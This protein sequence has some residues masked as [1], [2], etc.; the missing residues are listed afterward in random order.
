ML[1]L[2][3]SADFE[4]FTC[5]RLQILCLI[6][7]ENLEGENILLLSFLTQGLTNRI[8]LESMKVLGGKIV[9]FIRVRLAGQEIEH[10]GFAPHEL[11]RSKNVGYP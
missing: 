6:R 9:R 1:D 4:L 5:G 11:R 10:Y 2:S 3:Y 7:N 8:E